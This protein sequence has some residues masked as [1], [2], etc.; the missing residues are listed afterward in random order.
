MDSSCRI[1]PSG[2]TPIYGKLMRSSAPWRRKSGK[3]LV[4][5]QHGT[6][7]NRCLTLAVGVV[8]FPTKHLQF[9]CSSQNVCG[10]PILETGG[11]WFAMLF[12]IAKAGIFS[13]VQSQGSWR[14]E[15]LTK[16]PSTPTW[17]F[18]PRRQTS[19]IRSIAPNQ[20]D[21]QLLLVAH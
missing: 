6:S 20:R 15:R 1:Q 14:S 8:R 13:L 5:S 19:H 10:A 2:M 17:S 12:V 3:N 16:I 11:L 18:P 7:V 4:Y 21:P 9:S